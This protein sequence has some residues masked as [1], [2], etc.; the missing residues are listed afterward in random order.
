MRAFFIAF[1]LAL[2]FS[3]HYPAQALSIDDVDAKGLELTKGLIKANDFLPFCLD[4]LN[5]PSL[6]SG[7][8]QSRIHVYCAEAFR[9]KKDYSSAR[10]HL[11]QAL[12]LEPGLALAYLHLANVKLDQNDLSGAVQS[13]EDGMS[14]L[15][16]TDTEQTLY[17]QTI[18]EQIQ[19]RLA[20]LGGRQMKESAPSLSAESNQVQ[21][22]ANL[23][24]LMFGAMMGATVSTDEGKL[25]I[26]FS[27]DGDN[28]RKLSCAFV[29]ADGKSVQKGEYADLSAVIEAF[30]QKE[31]NV[32]GCWTVD[33]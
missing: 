9:Q 7:K 20:A 14:R 32:K 22:M 31:L 5:E 18:L 6:Q 26:K 13:L 21:A 17:A 23:P 3:F 8:D 29:R 24:F 12:R 25:E 15:P 11:E 16:K 30:S 1:A 27:P 2:G 10:K 28:G 33:P 19:K 4:A